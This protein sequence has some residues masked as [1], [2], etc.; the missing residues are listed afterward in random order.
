MFVEKN[1][2]SLTLLSRA[3]CCSTAVRKPVGNVNPD[4]QNTMGGCAVVAHFSNCSIRATRSRVQ[5]ASGF[6]EGY[7]YNH[8][9]KCVKIR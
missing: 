2:F 7:A 3:D 1:I 4:S 8:C 5:E 9:G 6:M